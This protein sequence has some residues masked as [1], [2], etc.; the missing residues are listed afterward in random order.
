MTT[1][2]DALVRRYLDDLDQ[3]LRDVP[4]GRRREL[5]DEMREHIRESLAETGES[6]S[7]VRAVLDRL[8]DPAEI[9]AEEGARPPEPSRVGFVEIG[10]LVGLALGFT[11]VGWLVGVA[12]LWASRRWTTNEKLVGTLAWPAA[13]LFGLVVSLAAS[14]PVGDDGGL[15]PAETGVLF[16][17]AF[18]P[19]VAIVY[20]ALRLRD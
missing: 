14:A 4:A 1:E 3:E 5:V 15:G 19:L 12:L 18:A 20:L 13:V 9:A 2:A 16:G 8:G 17:L 10:A 6:E 11:G 7:E